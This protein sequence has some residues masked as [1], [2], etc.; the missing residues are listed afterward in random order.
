M[1]IC[2]FTL[3]KKILIWLKKC[4]VLKIFDLYLWNFGSTIFS[5]WS[6]TYVVYD[7]LYMLTHESKYGFMQIIPVNGLIFSSLTGH[8][9]FSM[10]QEDEGWEEFP[11]SFFLKRGLWSWLLDTKLSI[12]CASP[13]LPCR[14]GRLPQGRC[15]LQPSPTSFGSDLLSFSALP[16]TSSFFLLMWTIFKV[17]IEFTTI[18]FLFSFLLFWLR[19]MWDLGFLTRH[20]AHT[21]CIRRWSHAWPCNK[22]FPAPNSNLTHCVFTLF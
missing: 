12:W 21:P 18:W 14:E 13:L 20:W 7:I 8:L 15:K 10:S 9:P 4:F 19:V 11:S 1:R 22:P 6:C 17:F 5:K 16:E 2:V 3:F